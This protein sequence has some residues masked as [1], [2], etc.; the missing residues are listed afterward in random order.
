[1]EFDYSLEPGRQLEKKEKLL[2]KIEPVISVITP[3]YSG[4]DYIKQVANCVLNQTYPY[5]EWLIINDGVEDLGSLKVLEEIE[6]MDD[7][8]KVFHKKNEGLAATRDYGASKSCSSAKYLFFLDDDD[9][10]EKTYFECAYWTLET[11]KEAAFAYSDSVGFDNINYVWSKW[12][13]ISNEIKE[14]MLVATAMIRKED[15]FEVGGYGTREKGI[16]E[17]WIFWLKL[18]SKGKFPVRMNYYAFWYRRKKQGELNLSRQKKNRKKTQK[19]MDKY[20]PYIAKDLKAIQYPKDDYEWDDV[21][22]ANI[23]SLLL[24][25]FMD[26]GK[27]KILMIIPWITMGGA[28]KFNLDMLNYINKEKYEVIVI[29]TE[30]NINQWR[31]KLE[32]CTKEVYDLTTFIDKKYWHLFIKYIIESRNINIIFNTNSLYGYEALPYLKYLFPNIPILDYI[33]MEEWYNRNGGYSRDSS[34]VSSVIDRTLTCNANSGNI[35]VDYFNRNEKEINTVYIGVDEKKFDASQYDKA[36][37]KKKYGIDESK[38]VINFICRIDYQKRPILFIEIMKKLFEKDSNFTCLVVGDGPL[39]NDLKKLSNKYQLTSINFLGMIKD[40]REIYAV[41]DISLN[42]S[43]KEGLALTSYESLSMGVPV[44]CSDVGGQ[45]ELIDKNVGILVPCMQE[46]ESIEDFNYSD[47]EV[48][49]YVDALLKIKENLTFYKKNARKRILNGFTIDQMVINMENEFNNLIKI[50]PKTIESENENIYLELI[51]QYQ[52]EYKETYSYLSEEV[53]YAVFGTK[54]YDKMTNSKLKIKLINFVKK[55]N[56][57][58]EAKLVLEILRNILH[59]FKSILKKV[60]DL[61][62]KLCR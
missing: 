16:N 50:K 4:K 24:P 23:D 12:F 1:M 51:N 47:S 30:P 18:F 28:D 22:R 14:N 15:F 26:N 31:Q 52:L 60:K 6:K 40:P 21:F 20:I 42:C 11:N 54:T 5:F 8:I 56:M 62:I 39:L 53:K 37:L 9:L 59:L 44:V 27:I 41:S 34:A 57:E 3:F 2:N 61:I 10:I 48:S 46:E 19:L 7:R 29:I 45:K 55:I 17:D 36:A 25:K 58:Q 35:L 33:H 38:T 43:I 32:Q 13:N 49:Y